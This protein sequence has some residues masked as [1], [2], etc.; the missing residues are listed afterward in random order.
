MRNLIESF[1]NTYCTRV[2]KNEKSSYVDL[3]MDNHK[4]IEWECN[5]YYVPENNTMYTDSDI[6][7][8]EFLTTC[9]SV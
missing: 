2:K 4:C 1:L 6:L 5:Q 9:Y 7:I 8:Y 3:M